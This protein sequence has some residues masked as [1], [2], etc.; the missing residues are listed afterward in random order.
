MLYVIINYDSARIQNKAAVFH[1]R[2]VFQHMPLEKNWEESHLFAIE[3]R[4][5][6]NLLCRQDI[7]CNIYFLGKR[8]SFEPWTA[9]HLRNVF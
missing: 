1:I 8:K 3:H 6:S 2:A 7:L 4:I 9:P 5:K